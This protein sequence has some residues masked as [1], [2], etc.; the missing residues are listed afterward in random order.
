MTYLII[1]ALGVGLSYLLFSC[2]TT[3]NT[4]A[5]A[6]T[7]SVAAQALITLKAGS[8]RGKCKAYEM[9]LFESGKATL[10]PRRNMEQDSNREIELTKVDLESKIRLFESN[11][12]SSLESEYLSPAKD[13]Q[14]FEITYE[15]KTVKF[16]KRRAPENL[17]K[18]W[19]ELHQ[20]VEE[21]NW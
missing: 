10:V 6:T 20:W 19:E 18:I 9:E 13:I 2:S 8:C 4:V 7:E 14:K 16:H 21:T 11:D 5:P 15:G 17:L 3:K 1:I 12:F